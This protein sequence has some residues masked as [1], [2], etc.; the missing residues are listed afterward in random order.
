[1]CLQMEK[2]LIP[3]Y[4]QSYADLVT[5]H[6]A[7]RAGFLELV[8]EKN[9]RSTPYVAQA[10]ALRAKAKQLPSARS[11]LTA[12]D[13]EA[14]LLAAAGISIKASGHLTVQDRTDAIDALVTNFLEPEGADWVDELVFRFLLTRGDTLGGEMRNVIGTL[15]NRKLARAIIANLELS[16]RPFH[17]RHNQLKKWAIGEAQNAGIENDLN[18]L[19][20]ETN[21][22]TRTLLFNLTPPKFTKNIDL[23]LVNIDP[24]K[25]S[26]VKDARA[27]LANP[28]VYVA[29]GELKSGFDP[30]GADE[31][32]KTAQ[33][34]LIRIRDN[35][36]SLTHPP[37]T[38][39][40]GAAIVSGMAED[41]WNQLNNGTLDFG[42]NLTNDTQLAGLCEWLTNL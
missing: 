4:L 12:T 32:W 19:K 31:H 3:S 38:F 25:Y 6:S 35:Y 10:K 27:A 8:L 33:T 11:L 7:T 13:L 28:E 2:A 1:M 18:G 16:N 20:W 40:V 30:A 41:I 21:G 34:A 5:P 9:R 39:F 15:G 29:F 26:K 22:H 42:A 17:W 24:T 37:A 36:S 14:P 23:C